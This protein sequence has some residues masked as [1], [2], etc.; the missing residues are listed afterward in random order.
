[1]FIVQVLYNHLI[2]IQI[3]KIILLSLDIKMNIL[4]IT[5]EFK[6]YHNIHRE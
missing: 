2:V 5:K 4:I 1:V 6:C 3:I